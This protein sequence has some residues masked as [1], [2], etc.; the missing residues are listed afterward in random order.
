MGKLINVIR[1]KYSIIPNEVFWDKRLDYRS[2]GLLCTIF[3]LPNGWD[4]SVR[5]LVKLVTQRDEDGVIITP[6]RGEGDKAIRAAV[7]YLENLGY[8]ERTPTKD[9]K[10]KF[11]GYDYKLNIPPIPRGETTIYCGE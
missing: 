10:G 6:Q 2:R 1:D 9:N 8:L 4:F 11:T 5:G 3:S 7:H